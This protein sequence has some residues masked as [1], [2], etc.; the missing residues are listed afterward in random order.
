M[1][2]FDVAVSDPRFADADNFLVIGLKDQDGEGNCTVATA[3]KLSH[4]KHFE[5][6]GEML[7]RMLHQQDPEHKRDMMMV[8]MLAMIAGLEGAGSSREAAS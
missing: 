4:V 8:M 6:I 3:A 2:V 5:M 1:T 7:G